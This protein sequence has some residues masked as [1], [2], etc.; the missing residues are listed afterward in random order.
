MNDDWRLQIDMHEGGRAHALTERLDA[1]QLEHDMSAA[2][3][4]RVIVSRDGARVFFY[5]GTRGQAEA[6][7]VLSFTIRNDAQ[8]W[9]DHFP[10][11]LTG[12][13]FLSD[14]A[15]LL[16]SPATAHR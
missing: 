2:F 8:V 5:A 9:G 4:D 3:H 15:A 11:T 7:K 13:S 1:E 6:V 10:V 16:T 12:V 14:Q